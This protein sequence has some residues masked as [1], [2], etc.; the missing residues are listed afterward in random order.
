MNSLVR[1]T[2]SLLKADPALM[3]RARGK[4]NTVLAIISSAVK[5]HSLHAFK[6]KNHQKRK[7]RIRFA[8]PLQSSVVV[9]RKPLEQST[10][11][12]NVRHILK[13][14]SNK[15]CRMRKSPRH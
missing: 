9:R 14:R 4:D 13:L 15:C 6:K 2:V 12:K 10:E 5:G 8:L 11:G 3:V 7:S 1:D